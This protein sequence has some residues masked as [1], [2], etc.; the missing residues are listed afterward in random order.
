MA[1]ADTGDGGN[2]TYSVAAALAA[3]RLHVHLPDEHAATHAQ[4]ASMAAGSMHGVGEGGLEG[5][6]GKGASVGKRKQMVLPR[7]DLLLVSGCCV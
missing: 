1:H 7:A 2:S 3:P 5:D 4:L 6:A